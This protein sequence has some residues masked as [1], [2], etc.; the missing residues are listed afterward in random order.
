MRLRK[1]TFSDT[2]AL[3]EEHFINLTPLID[4]V[5]V[6]LISFIVIAPIVQG[7]KIALASTEKVEKISSQ[8]ETSIYVL[9]DNTLRFQQKKVTF[10]ELKYLL[11]KRKNQN[12]TTPCIYHD[13]R[14][15]FGTYQKIKQLLESLGYK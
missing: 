11:S 3:S 13:E 2:D 5:F 7:E 15:S 8:S 6:V 1:K 14:A 12:N 4:V 10:S 9:K